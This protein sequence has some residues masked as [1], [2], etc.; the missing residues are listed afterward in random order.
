M[1]PLGSHMG[2]GQQLVGLGLCIGLPLFLA[3]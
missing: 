2:I 1:L 3:V